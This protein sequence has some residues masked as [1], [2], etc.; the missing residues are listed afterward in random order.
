MPI[1]EIL[2]PGALTTVQDSG[3]WGY[4]AW[5]VM[6]GGWLDDYAALWANRLLN[7][8]PNAALLEATLLGPTLK[9]E[10]STWVALS[11]ADMGAEV[12]GEPFFPGTS[13]FVEAGQTIRLGMA[14]LGARAYLAFAGG[15][16][17][18]PVMG[19]RSTDLVGGFGGYQGRALR[20]GDRLSTLGGVATPQKALGTTCLL[21]S[22]IR[23]LP[24]LH[25]EQFTP[26]SLDQLASQA[27]VVSPRSDRIGIR[28]QSALGDRPRAGNISQG[29]PMG[30]VQVP[31]SGEMVILLKSRGTIGGYPIAAQV[32]RRDWPIL[33]QLRPGQSVQFQWVTPKEALAALDGL[34]MPYLRKDV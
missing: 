33:A 12:D 8:P 19:S 30:A 11:G 17:V 13:R 27:H 16:A 5:G 7:N 10:D 2:K 34:E 9:V 18:D 15:I 32:I 4:A 14:K 29:M 3:R 1:I 24:G 25:A 22:V 26:A 21:S 6:V 31:P 20:A 23:V 28:L